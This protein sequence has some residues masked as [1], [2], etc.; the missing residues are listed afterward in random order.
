MKNL[1]RL[2]TLLCSFIV[3]SI[4]SQCTSD[5]PTDSGVKPKLLIV[6][7]KQLAA[8]TSFIAAVKINRRVAK[9]LFN[10]LRV[11]GSNKA[12]QQQSAEIIRLLK[13]S[14]TANHAKELAEQFGFTDENDF[15]KTTYYLFK[16]QIE[17]ATRYQNFGTLDKSVMKESYAQVLSTIQDSPTVNSIGIVCVECPFNN[18]NECCSD[19]VATPEPGDGGAGYGDDGP[20]CKDACNNIRIS[21][22]NVAE[23]QL[24]AEIS[25]V[26]PG[27]TIEITELALCLG[28]LGAGVAGTCTY[29]FCASTAYVIYLNNMSMAENN[30]TVC[31]NGCN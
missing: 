18:C 24:I 31:T 7:A 22:R 4:L 27:V 19:C 3:L 15:K 8:D 2:A 9:L 21:S 23:L 5:K 11:L 13:E 28:P 16:K 12:R 17:L 29:L 30:Y 1:M 10:K 14:G 20:S 6:S 26:C 25:L